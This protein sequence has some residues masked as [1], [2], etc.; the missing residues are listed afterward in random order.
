MR[1]IDSEENSSASNDDSNS[2][3][4]PEQA[5]NAMI[6][7][8]F[9]TEEYNNKV[10]EYV[11]SGY[12]KRKSY[13]NAKRDMMDV[14]VSDQ[15]FRYYKLLLMYHQMR[16]TKMHKKI[17]T[18]VKRLCKKYSYKKTLRAAIHYRSSMF[19]SLLEDA[20]NDDEEEDDDRRH[21]E[22]FSE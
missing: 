10:S 9:N 15:K 22:Q 14:H 1:P 17:M 2:S 7:A 8:I 5:W 19:R 18:D 4:P 6:V 11:M 21:F 12:A 13:E 20:I 3:S 16:K